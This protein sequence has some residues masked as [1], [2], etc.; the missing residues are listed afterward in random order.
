MAL[1]HVF[2]CMSLKSTFYHFVIKKSPNKYAE[3]SMILKLKL[4]QKHYS[5]TV[6]VW[7][8]L[9]SEV[10]G[11]EALRPAKVAV[12]GLTV[13][14][15]SHPPENQIL[16]ISAMLLGKQLS[17]KLLAWDYSSF[18]PSSIAPCWYYPFKHTHV[19]H[20]ESR[21][22]MTLAGHPLVDRQVYCRLCCA[23]GLHRHTQ[24]HWQAPLITIITGYKALR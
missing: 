20:I 4:F 16:D 24:G 14:W 18:G 10:L 11:K 9:V 23:T 1:C 22:T 12:L 19:Q 3:F 7:F 15:R 2:A 21:I 8:G 5:K 13:S 6:A 17:G